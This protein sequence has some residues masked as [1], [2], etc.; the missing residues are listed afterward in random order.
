MPM[1]LSTTTHKNNLK[2]F[3]INSPLTNKGI[4]LLDTTG[5]INLAEYDKYYQNGLKKYFKAYNHNNSINN[6][7][8][9]NSINYSN[10]INNSIKSNSCKN[11]SFSMSNYPSN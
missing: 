11:R 1:K 4:G 9:N 8:N 7:I 6:S 3:N 2:Y 5:C 10:S